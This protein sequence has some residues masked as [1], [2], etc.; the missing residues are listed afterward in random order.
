MAKQDTEFRIFIKK[1][2]ASMCSY[3]QTPSC[4]PIIDVVR[5]EFLKPTDTP[6]AA[7]GLC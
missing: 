3:I 7:L 6:D 1:N 5:I 2:S 4:E